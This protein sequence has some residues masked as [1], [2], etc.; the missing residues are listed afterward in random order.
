VAFMTASMAGPGMPSLSP[1]AMTF[2]PA[3]NPK[4]ISSFS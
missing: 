3:K 2:F 4:K 1:N